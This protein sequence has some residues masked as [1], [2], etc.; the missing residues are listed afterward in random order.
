MLFEVLIKFSS[1]LREAC[2]LLN[3]K[4]VKVWSESETGAKQLSSDRRITRVRLVLTSGTMNTT[5]LIC[6][7]WDVTG[8]S[9]FY[10]HII[11]GSKRTSDPSGGLSRIIE[12]RHIY[13][14]AD[15]QHKF[16]LVEQ[17]SSD[18]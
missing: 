9:G 18:N 13:M 11:T 3:I 1:A 12:T 5:L 7:N 17:K 14:L 2:E 16:S 10:M 15:F 8:K 6:F 4:Q